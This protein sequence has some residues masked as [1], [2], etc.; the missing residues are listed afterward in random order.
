MDQGGRKLSQTMTNPYQRDC[1]AFRVCD[2]KLLRK[3]V[4]AAGIEPASDSAPSSALH[5]YS[6]LGFN[7]TATRQDGVPLSESLVL[8][9]G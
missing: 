6:C 3:V 2:L 4:E 7:P 5:A 8:A 9:T 1:L